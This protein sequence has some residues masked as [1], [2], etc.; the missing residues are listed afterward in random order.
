M[1]GRHLCA[2]SFCRSHYC[3]HPD[4]I[5]ASLSSSRLHSCSPTKT[6]LLL[7][8]I[9]SSQTSHSDL[10]IRARP[11]TRV[12]A[13]Y[14]YY[15]SVSCCLSFLILIFIHKQVG[16]KVSQRPAAANPRVVHQL[17]GQTIDSATSAPLSISTSSVALPNRIHSNRIEEQHGCT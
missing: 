7:T 14:A 13:S 15:V 17:R 6:N 5:C 16:G 9:P 1:F 2:L 11:Y 4:N 10:R 8:S 12:Y 3:L